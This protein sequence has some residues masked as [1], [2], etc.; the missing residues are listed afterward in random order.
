MKRYVAFKRKRQG[1]EVNL[2]YNPKKRNDKL[3]PL[4]E[5]YTRSDR[6][7]SREEA[8]TDRGLSNGARNMLHGLLSPGIGFQSVINS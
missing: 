6:E 3:L 5:T 2:I 8:T 4:N 7:Y 1:Y